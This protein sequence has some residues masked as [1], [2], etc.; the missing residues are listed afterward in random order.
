MVAQA[1]N[2]QL[3]T[4]QRVLLH[5][6][7]QEEDEAPSGHHLRVAVVDAL[8][9]QAQVFPIDALGAGRYADHL[10]KTENKVLLSSRIKIALFFNLSVVQIQS[11]VHFNIQTFISSGSSSFVITMPAK[12]FLFPKVAL[13]AVNSKNL[14]HT[15]L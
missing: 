9:L 13:P 12:T 1:T 10:N 6:R 14:S 2:P 11:R 5:L 3:L 8:P 4:L 15:N 7:E